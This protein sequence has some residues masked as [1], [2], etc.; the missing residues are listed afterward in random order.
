MS[1]STAFSL[2]HLAVLSPT[3]PQ[4]P[5]SMPALLG[6]CPQETQVCSF[7]SQQCSSHPA[8]LEAFRDRTRA[9]LS[10]PSPSLALSKKGGSGE[11]EGAP[12]EISPGQNLRGQEMCGMET[13][14]G[15]GWG[16][17]QL[18]QGGRA[19]SGGCFLGNRWREEGR[20]LSICLAL[21]AL[22]KVLFQPEWEP[23]GSEGRQGGN[24]TERGGERKRGK[25]GAQAL[26]KIVFLS[27]NCFVSSKPAR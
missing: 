8:H 7:Y 17:L 11:S 21:C 18:C 10:L 4:P 27:L 3:F 20:V 16:G 2:M 19:R 26:D 23:T 24:G 12:G 5:G 6:H 13:E 1:T 22:G 9:G 14:T 25:E 15:R